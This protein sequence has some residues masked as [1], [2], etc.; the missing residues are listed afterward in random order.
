MTTIYSFDELSLQGEKNVKNFNKMFN[1]LNPN[2]FDKFTYLMAEAVVRKVKLANEL[3]EKLGKPIEHED[4]LRDVQ[5]WCGER[6]YLKNALIY[7]E[8]SESERSELSES[9][10][11]ESESERSELSESESEE[12]ESERSEL[13]K[14]ESEKSE[15]ERS[16]LSESESDVEESDEL[17]SQDKDEDVFAIYNY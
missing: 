14:S 4:K 13:S 16:E 6:L 17:S 8:E 2:Y 1:N 11:E 15:S 10:S 9:E 12:S 7:R 5:I 3:A